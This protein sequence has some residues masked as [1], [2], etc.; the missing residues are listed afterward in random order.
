[1]ILL[2]W[3][4]SNTINQSAR[5]SINNASHLHV[6]CHNKNCH[7][8][9]LFFSGLCSNHSIYTLCTAKKGQSK[10][11][12]QVLRVAWHS[13]AFQLPARSRLSA[14]QC[15]PVPCSLRCGQ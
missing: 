14:P 11:E 2:S 15:M 12:H 3:A 10:A 1:M 9:V 4:L 7:G 13:H 5:T 6:H 8:D